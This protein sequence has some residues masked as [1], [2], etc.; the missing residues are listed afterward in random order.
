MAI[1]SKIGFQPTLFERLFDDDPRRLLET[2]PV[3]RWS[4]GELK[5]SVARDVEDLL[6]SRASLDDDTGRLFPESF[7]SILTFGMG[8]FVGLSLASPAD[9]AHICR[10]LERTIVTHESR[11]R[12][13]QVILTPRDQDIG[14]LHFKIQAMLVVDPVEEPVSFNAELHLANLQYNING[15]R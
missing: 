1:Q 2:N 10:S 9:R 6:N 15:L 11:L 14:C 4:A 7:R 12:L 13:V 3:R 8:N 5:A